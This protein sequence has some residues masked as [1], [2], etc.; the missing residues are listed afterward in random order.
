MTRRN[1]S[2]V[3]PA[4]RRKLDQPPADAALFPST[5]SPSLNRHVSPPVLRRNTPVSAASSL[6]VIKPTWS[7]DD[8]PEISS[9]PPPSHPPQRTNEEDQP[10]AH[11]AVLKENT[12][13]TA[14]KAVQYAA[15]PF[16]LT[17]IRDL[18][19]HQ[20]ADTVQLKGILGS[21]M[22]KECWNFNF[23][24]D[25]DFVM[26]QFDEDV[27][28]LVKVKIVHGFWKRDD[29]R[30]INLMEVAERYSNVELVSAYLPDPFGTHHSKMLILFRHDDCAQIIVHTANMI[31]KDWT[32]MTQAVWQSPLL[33]LR[34]DTGSMES[35]HAI[36]TGDRFYLDLRHYLL[37][38]EKRLQRLI[39]QLALYDFMR[40]RAAFL[41]SAP[42]RQHPNKAD[43]AVHTSL[44]WLGLQE[45]LSRVPTKTFKRT[46]KSSHIVLQVSSIATLGAAPIWLSHFQSVLTRSHSPEVS[47]PARPDFN[48]I[49]PTAE[50]VRT[51]LDGYESGGSIHMRIQSAQQQKQLQYIQPLLCHW[52]YP[53]STASQ[54]PTDVMKTIQI[55]REA[56]RGPAAPHIK[57]Y[58]RF[59]DDSH[60][61]IDWALLT[62]ANLSKQA[63]GDVA[64]KQGEVRIQSYETGVL[65]WPELYASSETRCE[66]S[67]VPTFGKDMPSAEDVR[68]EPMPHAQHSTIAGTDADEDDEET[69]E[70]DS[71]VNGDDDETED[72]SEQAQPRNSTD[73]GQTLLQGLEKK[74]IVVGL[75]MPYDLPL[76]SYSADDVP[77]C[78]T[79]QYAEPDWKGRAWGGY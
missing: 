16:Q 24:F 10:T 43:P 18:A 39:D 78:A 17:R 40:I 53:P 36:G 12:K 55:R 26:Q 79:Q 31:P 19:A 54:P 56:H 46:K 5:A 76:R 30:R 74:R 64:N 27:R 44:G 7:F 75:R 4:K 48:I 41:G 42:S 25:L 28:S 29:E 9:T 32:N 47:N 34:S 72:E 61:N 60:S 57:T 70:D 49:F 11:L 50:E 3:P 37:S 52:K 66:V 15:S 20:N 71:G 45:I 2:N 38:Y 62:S 65:V 58:I 69:E 14:E 35:P 21:P 22:V 77:W 23:L 33:P 68:A 63:W 51:S 67:M 6:Q 73:R 13:K 1:G 8:V 59:S